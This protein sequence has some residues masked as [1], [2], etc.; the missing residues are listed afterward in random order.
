VDHTDRKYNTHRGDST[1][2]LTWATVLEI[3]GILSLVGIFLI[4]AATMKINGNLT[5]VIIGAIVYIATKKYYKE[6]L[7][8]SG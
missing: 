1:E 2:R 6:K 7:K 8:Q 3:I 4:N 5:G